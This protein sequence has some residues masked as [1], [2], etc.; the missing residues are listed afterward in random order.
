MPY[1]SNFESTFRKEDKPLIWKQ[2]N[3]ETNVGNATFYFLN[4]GK[5]EEREKE[6]AS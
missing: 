6:H 3:I 4:G 1:T 2:K 5:S